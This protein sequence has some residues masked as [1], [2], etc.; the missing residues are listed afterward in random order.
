MKSYE[1][2]NGERKEWVRGKE[3]A[4]TPILRGP[5]GEAS[6]LWHKSS[7]VGF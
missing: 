4:A 2:W 7:N 1:F 5:V 6:L 3:E